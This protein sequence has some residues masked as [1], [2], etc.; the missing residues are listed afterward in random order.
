M[1]HASTENL[2][3][4]TELFIHR[5]DG[6]VLGIVWT[7]LCRFVLS[8]IKCL[9]QDV[10]W[11]QHLK[12]VWLKHWGH[13]GKVKT[14]VVYTRLEISLLALIVMVLE[15]TADKICGPER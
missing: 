4:L 8:W 7:K 3:K 9:S 5:Q 12:W 11:P 6:S 15:I 10:K 2:C 1:R 13:S 14:L